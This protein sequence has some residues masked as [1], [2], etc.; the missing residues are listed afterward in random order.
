MELKNQMADPGGVDEALLDGDSRWEL[1]QRITASEGF[2][3]ASQLRSILKYTAKLA[4]LRPNTIPSEFEIACNV[5]GRREDFNPANDN[6]VRAQFSHLRRKL[7]HYFETEGKAEPLIL[8]IP[9]GSYSPVFAP[10]Q[11]HTLPQGVPELLTNEPLD[12]VPES[13]GPTSNL[14][15][16]AAPK[17]RNWRFGVLAGV[18]SAVILLIVL[19]LLTHYSGGSKELQ[20]QGP[21]IFVQFLSRSEGDVTIV[22]PDTSLVMI[23]NIVGA[24]IPLSEYIS[25]DFPQKELAM[26]KDPAMRNVIESLSNYRTTSANESLIAVDFFDTLKRAGGHA[27]IRFARDLHVEDLNVGNTVLIGG[28]SSDPWVT[29]FND[30]INFRHVD[31]IAEQKGYFENIHPAPG[32]QVQYINSYG[33]QSVGYV[34]IALTQNLSQSGYVLLINGADM[35][36]N[37]AA[38]RFLLHGRL[39]TEISSLLNRKDLRYFEL[40][41]RS[42]H[43]AGEADSTFEMVAFRI[44]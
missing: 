42:K 5:L 37:E 9:K 20:A 3:R 27:T 36:A 7:E 35:Q 32:E 40:F 18:N 8:T 13:T 24:N 38:A 43:I 31:N 39:P 4:L 2:Q 21:N 11:I 16:G 6:I 14:A 25:K 12:S 28:P 41:L 30:R 1:V 15:A 17:W 34:D 10:H 29:L 26:T 19:F 22:E 33:N 23:Q 44:K